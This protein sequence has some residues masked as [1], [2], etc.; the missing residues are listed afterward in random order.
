MIEI[1]LLCRDILWTEM[2]IVYVYTKKRSEFG[3]QPLFSDQNAQLN[4]DI[5]PDD[6]LQDNFIERSPVD[7]AIQYAP[8]MSE[9]E[10][11]GLV[12]PLPPYSINTP[13]MQK[14]VLPLEYVCNTHN[15]SS[16]LQQC[17]CTHTHT[18]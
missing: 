7:M 11:S 5:P 18:R 3:R 1:S 15:R 13:L 12:S 17:M 8:Q 4:V 14:L 6:S 16:P 10:V 2:E 9:H